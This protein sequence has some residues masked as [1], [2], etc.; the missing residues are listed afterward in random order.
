MDDG[1]GLLGSRPLYCC[2]VLL[3]SC[4]W[5]SPRLGNYCTV[6][7]PS[8]KCGQIVGDMCSSSGESPKKRAL[9]KS[10]RRA[11]LS[12]S[13][14]FYGD[15]SSSATGASATTATTDSSGA[16]VISIVATSEAQEGG[17]RHCANEPVSRQQCTGFNASLLIPSRGLQSTRA[18]LF[19]AVAFALIS[20]CAGWVMGSSGSLAR[21]T[22]AFGKVPFYLGNAF[23]QVLHRATNNT[24][25][26]YV[27]V[28]QGGGA[29]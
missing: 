4:S 17:N 2:T 5:L 9:S 24:K 29:S 10:P 13:H 3:R 7:R 25:R 19:G 6:C 26:R 21:M 8:S 20:A 14:N 22:D 23:K 27:C 28:R 15:P 12:D 18:V 11:D 1:I 16:G